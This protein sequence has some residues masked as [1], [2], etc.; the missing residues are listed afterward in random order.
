M[1]NGDVKGRSRE[2]PAAY[3]QSVLRY[4]AAPLTVVMRGVRSRSRTTNHL[5]PL[6]SH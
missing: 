4:E 6:T 1:G 5:S 2:P 3:L